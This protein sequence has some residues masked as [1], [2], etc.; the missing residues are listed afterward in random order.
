MIRSLVLG[1]ILLSLTACGN[2][3]A[4]GDSRG[5]DLDVLVMGVETMAQSRHPAG[6]IK[7][8]EDARTTGEVWNLAL[9]LEDANWMHDQD[10]A[11]I[12]KFVGRAADRIK[13]ARQPCSFWQSL[14]KSNRCEVAPLKP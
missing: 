1:L 2:K 10:K 8:A 14:W 12:V 5:S 11:R 4:K 7:R 13:L 6:E 9:D 3:L